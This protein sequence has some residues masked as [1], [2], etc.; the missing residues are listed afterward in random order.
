MLHRSV[1]FFG[2]GRAYPGSILVICYAPKPI[3]ARGIVR[4]WQ[5][6]P[7]KAEEFLPLGVIQIPALMS[8]LF[9]DDLVVF[10]SLSIYLSFFLFSF[11]VIRLFVPPRELE[12]L[13][14]GSWNSQLRNG[15]SVSSSQHQQ[16]LDPSRPD[17]APPPPLLQRQ[18]P[19]SPLEIAA[20]LPPPAYPTVSYP[21]PHSIPNG[22]LHS[23]SPYDSPSQESQY[24]TT[25]PSLYPTSTAPAQY[26]SSGKF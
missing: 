11:H 19:L 3:P 2:P 18:G 6:S 4:P 16:H 13:F 1:V 22:L 26:P 10:S 7:L 21:P 5:L 24:Y 25:H 14:E 12:D 9:L 8:S 17:L 15:S 23:H 20:S